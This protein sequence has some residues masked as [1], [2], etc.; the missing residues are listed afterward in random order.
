MKLE[1]DRD[2]GIGRNI[3]EE[4]RADIGFLG[5]ILVIFFVTFVTQVYNQTQKITDYSRILAII[6]CDYN[7]ALLLQPFHRLDLSEK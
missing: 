2:V 3:W 6:E 1:N 7:I 4:N 5:N